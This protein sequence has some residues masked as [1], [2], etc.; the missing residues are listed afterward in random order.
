MSTELRSRRMAVALAWVGALTPSPLPLSGLHKF[1]LGQP[2]WGV[3]Y[4]LLGWTQI[5]R[6][7]CAVEGIWLLTQPPEAFAG[8]RQGAVPAAEVFD[9][10]LVNA[11]GNALRELDTLRQEGLISEMEFEQKR[12]Q[13]LEKVG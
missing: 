4:L 10:N 13:L 5:P 11:L 9:P 6:I 3:V 7:A 1:Y 2:F 8:R 12:R